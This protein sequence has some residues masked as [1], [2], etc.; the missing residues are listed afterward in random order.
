M[1]F[2]IEQDPN[3]Y[4]S[5]TRIK[6]DLPEY[7]K[8]TK[9]ATK[10]RE[11]L[12]RQYTAEEIAVMRNLKLNT[13]YDHL[14]E[15]ALYDEQFPLEKY[16]NDQDQQEILSVVNRLKSYKLK[17]IRQEISKEISYFQ[18]RLVLAVENIT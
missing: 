3:K 11:L 6:N 2:T 13:I 15:I 1:L 8:T 4:P 16:I 14:V 10:T 5:L 18:I 9:S 17:D 12:N 7:T